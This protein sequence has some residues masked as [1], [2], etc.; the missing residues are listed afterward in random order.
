[1]DLSSHAGAGCTVPADSSM[2]VVHAGG[3]CKF[4]GSVKLV[5]EAPVEF[6]IP[7]VSGSLSDCQ[8]KWHSSARFLSQWDWIAPKA[9]EV[10]MK[11]KK[12]KKVKDLN[13]RF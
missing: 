9:A 5:Q 2:P 13:C 1:M 10:F 7:L 6:W 12:K 11:Q 4:G 3:L 8:Q